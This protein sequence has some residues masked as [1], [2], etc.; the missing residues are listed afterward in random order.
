MEGDFRIGKWTVQPQL[1]CIVGEGGTHRL[2]PKIM[3]VLVCLAEHAPQVVAK[4]RLLRRV[5]PDTFVSDDVLTRSISA[6]RR[7]FRDCFLD[8]D[9]I[10]TIPK[11]GYRLIARVQP[12]D[13]DSLDGRSPVIQSLAVLPFR[14]LWDDSVE[15]FCTVRMTDQLVTL[16]AR[17]GKL[18]VTAGLAT[19]NHRADGRPPLEVAREMRVDAVVEGA[20]TYSDSRTVVT[21]R[22]VHV[23]TGHLLWAQCYEH[24]SKDWLRAQARI[25]GQIAKAVNAKVRPRRSLG[26]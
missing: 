14:K 10:Q 3:Q 9:V 1:N 19:E 23:T 26:G 20:V 2:E 17:A 24:S 11:G 4:E 25:A 5:W 6:L 12:V 13:G 7:V 18:Q 21:A 8:P 16:L 15:R 22:L